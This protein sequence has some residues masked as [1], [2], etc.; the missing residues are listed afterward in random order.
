MQGVAGPDVKHKSM[1]NLYPLLG[2][3][4][5]VSLARIALGHQLIDVGVHFM[6]EDLAT[7]LGDHNLL[8]QVG[9][10]CYAQYICSF[11]F[12]N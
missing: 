8:P 10:V 3:G 11:K 5:V 12:G 9:L 7:E 4:P 1:A 2:M 6:P